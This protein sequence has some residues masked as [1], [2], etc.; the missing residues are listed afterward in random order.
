MMI[1]QQPTIE[2]FAGELV[3]NLGQVHADGSSRKRLR[4]DR[5]KLSALNV[6]EVA[7]LWRN[8]ETQ[9]PRIRLRKLL[10]GWS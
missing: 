8:A 3:L 6:A 7:R 10:I 5:G 4:T 2:S 9:I 1:E